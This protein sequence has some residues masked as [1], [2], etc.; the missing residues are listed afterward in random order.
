MCM[1]WGRILFDHLA[2]YESGED[3]VVLNKVKIYCSFV[4]QLGV[5]FEE[6][7]L[8]LKSKRITTMHE[9]HGWIGALNPQ[10][11]PSP[12]ENSCISQLSR[13]E[14][15]WEVYWFLN[16]IIIVVLI[17]LISKLCASTLCN[18]FIIQSNHAK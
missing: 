9:F 15:D 10:N 14:S 6:W 4:I 1:K 7:G 5:A 3:L 2:K 11:Q 16:R 12:L 17:R 8:E 18:S 13:M